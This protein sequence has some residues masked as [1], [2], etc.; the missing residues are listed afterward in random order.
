MRKRK[1]K[2]VSLILSVTTALSMAASSFGMMS[3][4][5]VH[6]ETLET[7]AMH[8]IYNPNSGE[9]F[10]TADE[11]EKDNL[12][13]IGWQY[14]GVGWYAPK[15]S[16]EAVYRL[17]NAN[18]G[19][20]HYTLSEDERDHLISVGWTYE[21]IGW[22]SDKAAGVPVYRQYNPNATGAG[23]H[24][25]TKDEEERDALVLAGW[26]DEGIGW[27]GSKTDSS[28]EEPE[29][30][31]EEPEEP[32]EEKPVYS[33]DS[34]SPS[35]KITVTELN[36]VRELASLSEKNGVKPYDDCWLTGKNVISGDISD[37]PGLAY[38][39]TVSNTTEFLSDSYAPEGYD[40]T[41]LI[42]WGK[43]PGLNTDI[44]KKYGYTGKGA[45]IAYVDQPIGEHEDYETINLHYVNNTDSEDSMHGPAVL[46]LLAGKDIGTSPDAEVYYYAH[47][48]WK[49]DQTTHAECLYQ[50][51]EQN[52]T[53]PS[54]KKIRMVGFS[55]NID[56]TEKNVEAFE[57][58]VKACEDA[59]IMVWFCGEYGPLTFLP[60]SD[61]DDFSNVIKQEW[62]WSDNN[63]DLVFVPAAG[64]TTS[65][66]IF[67]ADHIYWGNG[68]LSWTMPYMLGLYADAFAI[69]PSLTQEEIKK[70]IVDTAY[71]N[72]KGQRIVYPVNF[73]SEVL[74]KVGKT[75]EASE[76]KK[77]EKE[78]E[79]YIYAVI[80]SNKLSSQDVSAIKDHLSDITNAKVLLAD[81]KG[82]DAKDLYVTLKADA[83]KRAGFVKGIQIFGTNS[84]VPAFTANYKAQMIKGIDE[85]G[86]MQT[87]YFFGNFRNQVSDIESYSVYDHLSNNKNINLVPDWPVA[88]LPLSSGEFKDFFKKYDGFALKTGLTQREIV[89]FSNP[90]FASNYHIDD[91]GTF[92]T[93][94]D[95]E[96]GILN[97][98]YRLYGNLKGDYP[99]S[100]DVIGG[101]EATNLTKENKKGIY[102]FIINSHGQWNNVDN[103]YFIDGKEIRESL[104]NM[105]TI[106]SVMGKNPYYFDMWTC[107]NGWGMENNITTKALSGQC[108]GMFS[109]THV[110]SNNGVNCFA[111]L[112]DMKKSNFYYFYYSYLKALSKGK[113]RSEAFYRA[114]KEYAAALMED[115]KE[116]LRGEGNV[117]FNINN[118]IDYHNFG[119]LEP[120]AAAMSM[121]E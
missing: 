47:A 48:C 10:Y 84:I 18:A 9:H 55:D 87:D 86:T 11:D 92:L 39:L 71:V 67:G 117:Q 100:G 110:I 53:L 45:V 1:P 37:D 74:K 103:A 96:F 14:E 89:N 66:N 25:Y 29:E 102:E 73:I 69:D 79:K 51:I 95:E 46:S 19:D 90:I 70:L 2:L 35:G 114:Q 58:A 116:P 17:Y 38:S 91:M 3:L 118:L 36:P 40:I 34:V 82:S 81:M 54:D 42:E 99:V 56:D 44:L 12:V 50:I 5:A 26:K 120:N 97:V 43:D 28:P 15:Q 107:S 94:A 30:E 57:T 63:P 24:N 72:S 49:A 105:D 7:E 4:P 6:A 21:D 76:L 108:V 98:P 112:E 64:R 93:R 8:R 77:A 61:K 23:S 41:K 113:R 75:K 109:A 85:A 83:R 52:K 16:G 121:T 65:A 62:W 111:S 80:N 88:R 68:G 106:D 33:K 13:N 78:E 104:I 101:F 20:H 32:E 60:Y 31:P 22:Y 27:Y 59:G 115:S 119:L